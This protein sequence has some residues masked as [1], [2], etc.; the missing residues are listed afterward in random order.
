MATQQSLKEQEKVVPFRPFG[1]FDEMERMFEMMAPKGWL[2]SGLTQM[3]WPGEGKLQVDVIDRDDH[4][5][6]RAAI[7]GVKK[8]DLEVSTTDRT[9][10]IK[11]KTQHE[12]REEEEGE[13]Y[14]HEVVSG[15]FLRTLPLPASIDEGK[16]KAVFRDGLLELTLPKLESS[17]RH[18]VKIEE[19]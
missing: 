14:R 7:P 5:F 8:K 4:I 2:G 19:A 17:K 12:T 18:T 16:I 10:T 13:Y 15:H 1:M 11:G 9:I 3:P 6:V